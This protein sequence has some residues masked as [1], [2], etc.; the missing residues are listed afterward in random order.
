MTSGDRQMRVGIISMQRIFN[1]GSFL[2]AYALKRI[3]QARG[4]DVQFVDINAK[5][6]HIVTQQS[7]VQRLFERLKKCD[8]YLLRRMLDSRKNKLLNDL[9]KRE[10]SCYL[11]LCENHMTEAGCD[12][13]IIGSDEIFN[14]SSVSQWGIDGQRFGNIPAVGTVISYAASCGH[15]DLS[16]MADEDRQEVVSGL[17][18]LKYISVRDKN[19]YDFVK[20]VSGREAEINLDPVLIYD[21]QEEICKGEADLVPDFPYMI[22]YAY[23]NRIESAEEIKAIKGYAQERGLRTIAIGGSLPWCD[24]FKVLKPFQVLAYFKHASCVVTDTFHGTVFSIKL[25]K[26][27]AVIVRESNA[28]K[29]DDLIDRLDAGAHKVKDMKK[30]KSILDLTD[31]N[32]RSNAIITAEIKHTYTYLENAGL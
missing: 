14:C 26:P 8:E 19:T 1:Y 18:R 32:E 24:E 4:H 20:S 29:L 12:A 25:N 30:L 5:E 27:F 17:Q 31:D 28:N 3:I 11:G 2:Q 16:Y 22:V 21:F 9:L 13:V 6:G 7:K 23:H 10:Q 15:T